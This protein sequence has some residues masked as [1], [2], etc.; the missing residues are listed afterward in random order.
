MPPSRSA[1]GAPQR[2]P[3][4]PHSSARLVARRCCRSAMA[5]TRSEAQ[6]PLP[7]NAPASRRIAALRRFAT[8]YLVYHDIERVGVTHDCA[9]APVALLAALRFLNTTPAHRAPCRTCWCVRVATVRLSVSSSS[10]KHTM[11]LNRFASCRS[12]GAI[13]QRKI[14]LSGPVPAPA[15]VSR[16]AQRS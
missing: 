2:P 7:G 6:H 3:P 8:H 12:F 16:R 14:P 11:R 4:R 10:V 5:N 1:W 15:R 9:E 13:R